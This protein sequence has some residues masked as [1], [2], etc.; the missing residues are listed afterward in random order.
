MKKRI[1][2]SLAVVEISLVCVASLPAL[3]AVVPPP[4]GG[5]PGFNTAEGQNALFSLSTGVGNAAVGWYSLF[6]NTDGSFNTALGAGA[7]AL[8]VGN[9]STSEG[10][11]NTGIGAAALLFNTT[12]SFNTAVGA[13]SLLNNTVGG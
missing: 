13:T 8:N 12:G 7:L 1:K 9:Q 10:T 2:T 11:Q 3:R 6:S 5:Y 4:D